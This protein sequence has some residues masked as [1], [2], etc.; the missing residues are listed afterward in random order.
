MTKLEELWEAYLGADRL[1]NRAEE[2]HQKAQKA[3]E[4]ALVASS[5]TF[6]TYYN[7]S[8]KGRELRDLDGIIRQ[9]GL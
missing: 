2:R 8:T 5:K 6:K 9:R 3:Y 4:A 1:A 7:E